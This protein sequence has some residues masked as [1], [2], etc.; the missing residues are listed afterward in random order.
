MQENVTHNQDNIK[1]RETDSG[2]IVMVK[3][4]DKEY[5]ELL[6]I[7][8]KILKNKNYERR[9]GNDKKKQPNGIL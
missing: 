1:S 6:E 9:N 4:A 8:S 5:K 2:I 3:L 7:Y